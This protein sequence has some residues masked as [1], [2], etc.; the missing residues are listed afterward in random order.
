MFHHLLCCRNPHLRLC[1]LEDMRA[2]DLLNQLCPELP[3]M[4]GVVNNML[5][6]RAHLKP[7][8]EMLLVMHVADGYMR[9]SGTVL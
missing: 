7:L 9:W 8:P 1:T 5:L 3:V 4:H 2:L 6:Q